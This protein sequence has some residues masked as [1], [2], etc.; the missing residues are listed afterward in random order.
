MTE[1]LL[2]REAA[3]AGRKARAPWLR[4]DYADEEAAWLASGVGYPYLA[5]EDY[6][7]ARNAFLKALK[8]SG[9][10]CDDGE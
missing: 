6:H 3:A 10:G 1:R 7:P 4:G 5:P 9:G 2:L 8:S